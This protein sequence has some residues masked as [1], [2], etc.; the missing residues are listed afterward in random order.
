MTPDPSSVWID[1][2]PVT[3]C[4]LVRSECTRNLKTANR[5]TSTAPTKFKNIPTHHRFLTCACSLSNIMVQT[6]ETCV[7]TID[8]C[9]TYL[10]TKLDFVWR[11]HDDVIIDGK[12]G[13]SFYL[14]EGEEPDNDN[15]FVPS[16]FDINTALISW[17]VRSS[18]RSLRNTG[19]CPGA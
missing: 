8:A 17:S 14:L 1:N 18:H 4:Q 5:K 16:P 19:V 9:C 7:S 3:F 12:D 6:G 2:E 11:Q 15:S 13:F 10:V